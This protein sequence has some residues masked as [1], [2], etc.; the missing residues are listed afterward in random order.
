MP[1][2]LRE[3]LPAELLAKERFYLKDAPDDV[4][5]ACWA[6]YN[7][8]LMP[9]HES[10]RLG[11]VV[12]QF[13]RWVF[14]NRRTHRYFEEIRGRLGPFRAAVEF[15]N[16]KW[17]APDQR[18]TTLALLGDLGFAYICVD[19]PQ[20]FSSSVPPIAEATTDMAMVRF[21]GRNADM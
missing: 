7:D 16:D 13:P 5:D 2:D 1:K 12:F 8:G 20:G 6:A 18:E 9:L 21:H 4:V 3:M 11:L 19:E 15:R 14:P 17:M 10:G